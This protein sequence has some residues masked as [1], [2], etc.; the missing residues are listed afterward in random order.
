MELVPKRIRVSTVAPAVVGTPIH[1][2]FIPKAEV[3]RALQGFNAFH[4]IG[5]VGTPQDVADAV[6]FLLSDKAACVTGAIWDVD[7][8][9]M[10]GRNEHSGKGSTML[11]NA[12]FSQP[13]VVTPDRY[14]WIAS[15]QSGVERVMLDRIGAEQARATSIVRYA[16]DSFF[17]AHAHPD[18]EE[19]LVLSG[20]FSD[21]SGDFPAGWYLRSPSGSMHQPFSRPG[22]LIFVKLRQ[23]APD[24]DRRVRIDTRDPANW[25][26]QGEGALCPLFASAHEQVCLQRLAPGQ[27]LTHPGAGG[28]ELLVLEGELVAGEQRYPRGTWIRL[29]AGAQPGLVAGDSGA[30]L[31]LK[32]GH[33]GRM[34]Q[35][36]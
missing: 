1:E 9:V 19:I 12:D 23:M 31:Y 10:A 35:A 34:V 26:Q 3:H 22:A 21:E 27:A 2:G 4:P 16:P 18:G 7:G 33:L 36:A 28:A 5:R 8:G 30:N 24:E 25:T 17:P 32:T 6:S 14:Q 29:P 13:V 11:V 20:T 15:P